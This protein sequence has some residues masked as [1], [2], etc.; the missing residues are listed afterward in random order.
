MAKKMSPDPINEEDLNG[1]NSNSALNNL[2]PGDKITF[3]LNY[4][5]TIP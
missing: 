1:L 4:F 3:D 5:T 2:S